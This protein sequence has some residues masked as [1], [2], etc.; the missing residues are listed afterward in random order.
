MAT[1]V[2]GDIQGCFKSLMSLL[3]KIRFDPRE[4]K[5]LL[6]GDL[7]NR[8]PDSLAVL[9]WAR[10]MKNRVTA[11][12]GNHDVHLLRVAAGGSVLRKKDTLNEVLEA[13]DR[14]EL[15]AWLKTRPLTVMD[16]KTL[17]V[18]AG[19]LPQWS[20]QEAVALGREVEECLRSDESNEFLRSLSGPSL[21][22][23]NKHL[24]G[25]E[26][27]RVAL[28]VFTRLRVC[29]PEGE[30]DLSFTGPPDKAPDGFLPWYLVPD[31]KNRNH[32][33]VFGHWAAN[34]FMMKENVI[35][36]DSGCVWGNSLSA[37]RLEDRSVYQVPC[38]KPPRFP[39]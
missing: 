8:G 30:M 9:R 39:E 10:G 27:L 19:L 33:V 35:G 11:V 17:I 38:S 28:S 21:S 25:F 5:I 37:V 32:T 31:R 26:R 24:K 4:D 15:L 29:T 22:A 34:G 18:H 7:I 36:L 6:V 23:W 1:Y 13:P 14:D 12:L 20:V 2:V 3:E 16:D